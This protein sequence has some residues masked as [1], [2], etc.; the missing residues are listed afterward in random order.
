MAINLLTLFFLILL[1]FFFGWLT[2]RSWRARN[3]FVKW[4]G[5]GLG[6]LL[7]LLVSTVTVVG[8]IGVY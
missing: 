5:A 7:T 1:A 3:P 4:I 8:L 6:G 2:R